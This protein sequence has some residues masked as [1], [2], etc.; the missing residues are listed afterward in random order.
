MTTI[1]HTHDT[2][3]RTAMSDLRVAREFFL[4]HLPQAILNQ[5][6]LKHLKL[7]PRSHINDI[8][9]ETIVD[10][11]YKT[12]IAQREAYLYLL[13]EH[14]SSPDELM[15][16]RILK[17][18]CNVIDQ[19]LKETGKKSL[20]LI[21]PIVIYHAERPYPYSTDI[22]EL[23]DAPREL[24]ERYFLKPFQL[25]DLARI[26]DEDLKRYEWAGV[27]EFALK[28]IYARDILPAIKKFVKILHRLDQADGREFVS[29]VLE[30]LM[31]RGAIQDK[32]SFYR[33]INEQVSVDLGEKVMTIA[34]ELRAEGRQKGFMEGIEK[35]LEQGLEK[36]LEQGLEQ[37]KLEVA[38]R[39]LMEGVEALF[40]AKVTGLPL[41]QIEEL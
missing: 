40:V 12:T 14:Q 11:L 21:Y 33:L 35:G 18:T 36:G 16:F 9:K 19:H 24:V 26:D 37:G 13:V 32:E 34:E 41:A 1:H 30:Y 28:H 39:L 17:Y 31:A 25:I 23:V 8:R 3:V 2:F 15:A 4:A 6:D 22:Q 7:Q 10:I 29:I 38:K 20:P 27:M 5:M